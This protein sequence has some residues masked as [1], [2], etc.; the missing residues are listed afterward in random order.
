MWLIASALAATIVVG[1]VALIASDAEQGP[2]VV[3]PEPTPLPP[4]P[5][6]PKPPVAPPEV[7]P[8]ADA[9]PPVARAVAQ[10]PAEVR[11]LPEAHAVDIEKASG[12]IHLRSVLAP[13]LEREALY[14]RRRT[15]ERGAP[16]LIAAT[17]TATGLTATMVGSDWV[18]LESIDTT[19]FVFD[20][21]VRLFWDRVDVEVATKV[22]GA[23]V[24]HTTLQ[25]AG[26]DLVV[27]VDESQRFALQNLDAAADY[28]AT[29]RPG[30][31]VGP[32]FLVESGGDRV[33]RARRDPANALVRLTP[34]RAA[35]VRKP[36]TLWLTM[37]TAPGIDPEAATVDVQSAGPVPTIIRG[38]APIIIRGAPGPSTVAR[39]TTA[40]DYKRQA[41]E[42]GARGDWG[43]ALDAWEA[44]LALSPDPACRTGADVARRNLQ[45]R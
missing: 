25:N 22:K 30:E 2:L 23:P 7:V 12:G 14:V 37:L 18:P 24:L 11:L 32:V 13:A 29:L 34:G 36:T 40:T 9:P 16:R 38:T 5:P 10:Y 6:T 31:R 4:L 33:K 44:C 8:E 15:G 17:R 28:E 26:P 20:Q 45:N 42:H 3:A 43:P 41:M 35:T 1:L 27:S 21:Q 39:P 19:V